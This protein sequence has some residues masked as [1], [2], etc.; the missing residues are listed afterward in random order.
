MEANAPP[1]LTL[2]ER[3]AAAINSPGTVTNYAW[4][5]SENLRSWGLND[6]AIGFD[7]AYRGC[8]SGIHTP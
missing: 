2:A 1:P 6:V 5:S 4:D 8:L 3:V 7:R